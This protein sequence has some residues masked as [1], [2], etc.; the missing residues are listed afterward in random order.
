MCTCQQQGKVAGFE[1]EVVQKWQAS[2]CTPLLQMS[3]TSNQEANFFKSPDFQPVIAAL[4]LEKTSSN[5]AI[6]SA[7]GRTLQM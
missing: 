7:L 3:L 6:F 2:G 4:D 1:T 5:L